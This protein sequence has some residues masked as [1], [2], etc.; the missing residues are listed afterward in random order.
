LTFIQH[1]AANDVHL[2]PVLAVFW[3]QFC[4]SVIISTFATITVIESHDDAQQQKL[5]DE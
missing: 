2:F 4:E 1:N 5:T 3:V